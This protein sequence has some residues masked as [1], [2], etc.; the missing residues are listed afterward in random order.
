MNLRTITYASNTKIKCFKKKNGGGGAVINLDAKQLTLIKDYLYKYCGIFLSDTK[1]TMI[2]NRIYMLMNETK[3]QSIDELLT[4]IE[5]TKKIRQQFIN[6]FTTNKT[7]F[8][9]EYLHFQDMIDRSLPVL[10][11]LNRPIKIFC[12][13]S[14]T[15]QEPYS[16]AMSVAYAK[17]INK[18]NIPVSIIATDIDT[19]VLQKAQEGIYTINFKLEKFPQWCDINEYFD[20][21]DDGKNASIRLLKV[22]DNLKS[23]ITF[24]QLNL[25]DKRYPFAREEFDILFCRNVLIYFTQEDQP[26]ILSQL[27]D[28]LRIDGTFYLGHSESLYHLASKFEKLG[29]KT[30]VKIKA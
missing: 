11:G 1:T 25:F 28:T 29:N 6:S 9:R 15:G 4:S 10:F 26:K 16:I 19:E 3:I 30:F 22:K 13:A 7:D 23:M 12:C 5:H 8:F 18:T 24:K 17:K 27:I 21:L 20:A 2:K 14:S